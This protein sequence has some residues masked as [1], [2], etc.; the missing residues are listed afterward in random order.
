MKTLLR[1]WRYLSWKHI[2]VVIAAGVLIS[3]S[4]SLSTLQLNLPR[5]H[6]EFAN[7]IKWYSAFAAV[8]VLAI[9]IVEANAPRR[10]PLLR[11]YVLAA[12][13]S[14]VLCV[15]GAY[16]L[17]DSLKMPAR[18]DVPGFPNPIQYSQ[19]NARSS[20]IFSVSF[21]GVIHCMI[22]MFVYVRL[23]NARLTARALQRTQEKAGEAGRAAASA[24][25][26]LVRDRID[27][28]S[29]TQSLEDIERM[30]WTDPA[31]AERRL[32]ELI[33]FLR[34]AIPQVRREQPARPHIAVEAA[35]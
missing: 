14:A 29:L 31:Q 28:A 4:V 33:E 7:M 1:T 10:R 32:D 12:I 34:A 17:G 30:Y 3:L 5:K 6:L 19:A 15:A 24:R 20:A 26:D 13:A 16:A 9:A 22:G 11:R 25:L 8:F 2:V 18:R 27:P 23:R 35:E 21:E